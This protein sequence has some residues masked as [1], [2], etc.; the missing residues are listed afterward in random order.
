MTAKTAFAGALAAASVL[1]APCA[2]SAQTVLEQAAEHR[3]QLDFRVNDE[4]LA[5]ML[6]AGWEAVIATQG[7]A[8]DANLR[9]IF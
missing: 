9:M 7:P 5:K 3:F 4:A 6:P 1:L 2:A 8:K